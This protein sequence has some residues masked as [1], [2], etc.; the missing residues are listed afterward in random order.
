M[1]ADSKTNS[2]RRMKL[3]YLLMLI[4]SVLVLFASCIQEEAANAEA[5]I[6]YCIVKDK[7]ILKNVAD[8]LFKANTDHNRI[9]IRVKADADLSAVAPEFVLTYGATISPESGSVHDFNNEAVTYTVTSQDG[10][11]TKTYEISFDRAEMITDF[12]F[13][14]F[15]LNTE[16]KK[17]YQWYEVSAGDNKQ[18]DWA[19]GNPGFKLAKAMA[20]PDEY[21]TVPYD[22][23][24]RGNAVKLETRSTGSFGAMM[25]MRL[26]AG[27]LFLGT[28]DATYALKD[29]MQATC[30]GLP[31][32]EEPLELHGY[33]KFKAGEDFQDE[34]GN[35]LTDV[36]DYCDIYSVFYENTRMIN[37]VEESVILRGD[38]VLT[39]PSIVALA[40]IKQADIVESDEWTKFNLAFEYMKELDPVRLAN[41]GYN[42]SVVFSSSVDGATFRGA[43]G[44]VLY[45]DEVSLVCK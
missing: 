10:K 8:T 37:G 43:V 5:D 23:G 38:D 44:S 11:W 6:E 39:H 14:H 35:I 20:K 15:E 21:P 27:N 42:F 17:Y 9:T 34:R 33:Y 36:K 3:N 40:R 25:N 32:T 30:F 16:N 31:F 12:H 29:A 1:P 7:D 28:F 13:E 19:T 4:F 26:A 45:I 41:Y 22:F 24:V 2:Y 18:Y